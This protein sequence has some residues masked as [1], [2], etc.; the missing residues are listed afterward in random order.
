LGAI[1]GQYKSL[2][3]KQINRARGTP[4][5]PVWQRNYYE[6]II[7]NGDELDRI[8]QYIA[9]NPARWQHDRENPA[10]GVV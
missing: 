5:T 2:V 3:T 10:A 1:I 4:G 9:N 6:H 8:R 7:R